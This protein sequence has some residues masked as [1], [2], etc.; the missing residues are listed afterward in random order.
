MKLPSLTHASRTSSPAFQ[1]NALCLQVHRVLLADSGTLLVCLVDEDGQL[2]QLRQQLRAT[3]P[4]AP[5]RQTQIVHI[6]VLRLLTA[7]QLDAKQRKQ[8]Q[9]VCDDFT[10]KM[11]GMEVTAHLLW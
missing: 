8:L 5:Q 6:S 1:H 3:F 2:S 11:A 9:A 7:Q 10:D 4:G